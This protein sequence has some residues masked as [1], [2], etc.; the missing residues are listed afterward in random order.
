MDREDLVNR[1]AQAI[2]A[3]YYPNVYFHGDLKPEDLAAADAAL[4]VI[5]APADP[6]EAPS[7]ICNCG[8]NGFPENSPYSNHPHYE[9]CPQ[10]DERS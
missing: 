10:Y 4:R 5:E 9:G 2:R 7:R 1:M 6:A 3:S 8:Q